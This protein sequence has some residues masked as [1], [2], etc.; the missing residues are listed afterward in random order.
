MAKQA[1][2][3]RLLSNEWAV[4]YW[5]L[6]VFA[7][8]LGILSYAIQAKFP[9]Q[10]GLFN[11][12]MFVLLL[13]LLSIFYRKLYITRVE[14]ACQEGALVLTYKKLLLPQSVIIPLAEITALGVEKTEGVSGLVQVPEKYWLLIQRSKKKIYLYEQETSHQIKG[15]FHVLLQD[16]PQAERLQQILR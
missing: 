15:L 8:F 10:A 14:V 3:Y 13:L 12:G 1:N 11:N 2:T 6:G 4:P 9:A 5:L 16:A 7:L